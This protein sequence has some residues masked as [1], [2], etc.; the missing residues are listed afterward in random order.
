MQGLPVAGELF[1]AS[2][3]ELSEGVFYGETL[4]FYGYE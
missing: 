1:S 4:N 2:V 3:A